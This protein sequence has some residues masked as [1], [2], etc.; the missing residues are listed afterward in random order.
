MCD[1]LVWPCESIHRISQV[2]LLTCENNRLYSEHRHVRYNVACSRCFECMCVYA[3]SIGDCTCLSTHVISLSSCRH[4]NQQ[5]TLQVYNGG[6]AGTSWARLL[7]GGSVSFQEQLEQAASPMHHSSSGKLVPMPCPCPLPCPAPNPVLSCP[8]L[9]HLLSSW[10]HSPKQP[11][12]CLAVISTPSLPG[13]GHRTSEPLRPK[14]SQGPQ[15]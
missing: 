2:Q 15:K 7:Q 8:S 6:A 10:T 5:L 11:H 1:V 12:A 14:D 4:L 3:L 9:P 13:I